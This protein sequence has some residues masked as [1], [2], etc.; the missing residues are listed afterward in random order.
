MG[1][2]KNNDEATTVIAAGPIVN[3][4]RGVGSERNGRDA[5]HK[6]SDVITT[7]G[8]TTY[9]AELCRYPDLGAGPVVTCLCVNVSL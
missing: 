5:A 7:L 3:F 1:K 9:I 2:D 4:S 6:K 8:A